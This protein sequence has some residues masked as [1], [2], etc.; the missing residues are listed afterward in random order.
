VSHA[1]QENFN[2]KLAFSHFPSYLCIVNQTKQVLND[3]KKVKG[4]K[5]KIISLTI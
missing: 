4:I 2:K 3:I 1:S 5:I